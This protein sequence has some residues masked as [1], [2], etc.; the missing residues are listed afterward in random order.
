MRLLES[1]VAPEAVARVARETGRVPPRRSAVEL[2]GSPFAE[3]VVDMLGG[4]V[5]RPATPAYPRVSAQLQSMV[6]AVLTGRLTPGAAARRTADRIGAITGLPVAHDAV[7][8][9]V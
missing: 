9:P 1:V 4:A 2:I 6:E 7:P 8:A 3:L 5:T